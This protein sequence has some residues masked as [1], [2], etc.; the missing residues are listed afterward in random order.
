[1]WIILC[2]WTL[3]EIFFVTQSLFILR[4]IRKNLKVLRYLYKPWTNWLDFDKMGCN[5][6]NLKYV[7]LFIL[8]LLIL[9][10]WEREIHAYPNIY[11]YMS[12][13]TTNFLIRQSRIIM[14]FI[15]CEGKLYKPF[16]LD[17][18]CL[19]EFF[20]CNLKFKMIEQ[21]V[22]SLIGIYFV[23]SPVLRVQPAFDDVN[24]S[25]NFSNKS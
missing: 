9:I 5:N 25:M 11:L 1:M 21:H 14:R 20:L 18:F 17:N 10:G 23:Q 8:Y 15:Y 16:A 12:A 19:S 13:T 24:D 2:A 7:V 4:R 6:I 3:T 22:Y